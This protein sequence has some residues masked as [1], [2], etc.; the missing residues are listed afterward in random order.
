MNVTSPCI[1][2]CQMSAD[3]RFCTGCHRSLAEIAGWAGLTDS[4]KSRV[5]AALNTRWN[6]S[7][8]ACQVE[9]GPI[10]PW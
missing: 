7:L 1:G 2:I 4:E 9:A 3:N 10:H 5:N 6:P 8:P